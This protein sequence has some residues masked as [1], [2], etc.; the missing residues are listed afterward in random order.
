VWFLDRVLRRVERQSNERA[1]DAFSTQLGFRAVL[2]QISDFHLRDGDEA[3]DHALANAVEAVM[4]VR[5][6]P[7]A[8]LAGGD[9]ADTPTVAEYDRVK[10]LLAPLPIPVYVLA[11]NHDDPRMLED[12]FGQPQSYSAD[13]GD[14]RLVVCETW[15]EGTDAGA[16]GPERLAWLESELAADGRLP[17]ILA[18]HHPPVHIGLTAIDGIGLP[19]EDG[20]ALAELLPRFP[21][22]RRVVC[23]HVHRASY[24]VLA[25][26]PVV[27]VPSTNIQAK[28]EFGVDE[29]DMVAETPGFAVHALVD[30]EVVSH[31]QP[32]ERRA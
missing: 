27:T 30:G 8:V 3:P 16:L 5:P 12:A 21:Q 2:A 17:T 13:V 31:I 7:D 32:V 20:L 29:F 10:R 18:L 26:V 24:S 23:G 28:L 19:R 6:A 22:V 1:G 11:G 15:L 9:L 4:A 14:M 25:G